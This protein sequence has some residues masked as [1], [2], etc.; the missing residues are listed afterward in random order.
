MSKD[1]LSSELE[2]AF[3]QGKVAELP[4][5]KWD[6]FLSYLCAH[7]ASRVSGVFDPR[8]VNRGLL[9]NS[10][11]TF[12]FIDRIERS[13]QRLTAITIFISLVAIG[14][15][16]YTIWSSDSQS[17]NIEVIAVA[18]EKQIQLL[19]EIL[20]TSQKTETTQK[21]QKPSNTA[22]KRDA[23]KAARPLP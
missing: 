1:D 7:S 21:V 23:P 5:E 14:V 2:T 19:G 6:K 15:S 8:E 4:P 20:A 16:A 17:K 18:Q 12:H 22:V 10:L 3:H 13:N 9:L 11:K